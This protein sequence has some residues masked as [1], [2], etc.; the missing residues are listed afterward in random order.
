MAADVR[1]KEG[2]VSVPR[3][4]LWLFVVA[5]GI[6][7]GGGL[8]ETRVVVPLWSRGVPDTLALGHP[9]AQVATGAGLRFWAF[10][11]PAAGLLALAVLVFAWRA[12][13]SW[14]WWG[15]GAAAVELC[16]VVST[17]LYFKPT[18]IR[19][20]MGHGAGLSHG[21]LV[22]TVR[23]WVRWNYVRAAV[24]FAAWC[25]ALVGLTLS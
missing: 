11:T 16:V 5:L 20:F 23:Q 13:A 17:L 22:D 2:R 24:T 21:A 14:R 6:D 18:A 7:L 8:Y 3:V 9:L 12:P 19:L 15:L 25:A 1:G 4:V 10:V